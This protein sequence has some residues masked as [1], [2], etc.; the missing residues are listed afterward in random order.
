MFILY[1]F[2]GF[3]W[4]LIFGGSF[5]VYRANRLRSL[6]NSYRNGL[7]KD[8]EEREKVG[9][10]LSL[11]MRKNNLLTLNALPA[12]CEKLA[13]KGKGFAVLGIIFV[14]IFGS[15]IFYIVAI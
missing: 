14:L 3:G 5:I 1:I 13:D 8:K 10:N 4:L 11:I 6:H 15:V 12:C 9:L 2:F 7:T